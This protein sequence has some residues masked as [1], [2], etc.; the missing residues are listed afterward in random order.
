MKKNSLSLLFLSITIIFLAT[1]S[2]CSKIKN[3]DTK[4][5]NKAFNTSDIISLFALTPDDIAINTPLYI[6][7]AKHNIREFNSWRTHTNRD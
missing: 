1:L 7:E 5:A 3:V 4:M 2:Y 6:E